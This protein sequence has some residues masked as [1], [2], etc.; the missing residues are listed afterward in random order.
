MVNLIN[1]GTF[2]NDDLAGWE[3]VLP[4]GNTGRLIAENGYASVSITS[5]PS[6][7]N[8]FL[9]SGLSLQPNTNYELK[10]SLGANP[11][12]ISI[13]P[14]LLNYNNLS[15]IVAQGLI[16][17]PVPSGYYT[18]K[19]TT[20]STVPINACLSFNL[21]TVGGYYFDEVILE[22]AVSQNIIKNPGFD[23]LAEW[24]FYTDGTAYI[25]NTVPGAGGETGVAYISV[26]NR[27]TNTQ[28]H[29]SGIVLS[30]NT[31]Y[32][33][34]YFYKS[35]SSASISVSVIN[36]VSPYNAIF[37][38]Y[39]KSTVGNVFTH[40]F[41]TGVSVPANARLLF[42][43][44][45]SNTYYLFDNIILEATSAPPP[46]CTPLICTLTLQ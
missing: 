4:I 46:I 38:A 18:V 32:K 21:I 8:R 10:V 19:F 22:K 12:E 28:L 6:G 3:L 30:P 34:S 1:N 14:M 24:V 31:D 2:N 9:T 42:V 7:I 39:A 41:R 44:Y 27:G 17:G 35:G 25:Y 40:T 33:L 5:S 23:G 26:P 37:T 29:Q 20:G 11:P 45:E 13:Q 16:I 36:H 43:L 15:E